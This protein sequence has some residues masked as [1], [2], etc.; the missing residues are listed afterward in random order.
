[1]R[2]GNNWS[3]IWRTFVVSQLL[4]GKFEIKIDK[5]N[6]SKLPYLGIYDG[7]QGDGRRESRIDNLEDLTFQG[8]WRKYGEGKL[9]R[10]NSTDSIQKD[11][12]RALASK[13]PWSGLCLWKEHTALVTQINPINFSIHPR[14]CSKQG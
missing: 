14:P 13:V 5:E 3:K 6:G 10:R 7:E 11:S 9:A 8:Q 2:N 4:N 12:W 1:M